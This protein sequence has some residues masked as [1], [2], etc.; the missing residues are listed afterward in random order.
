MDRVIFCLDIT[1]TS[2][3]GVL[4]DVTYDGTINVLSIQ[5]EVLSKQ[6]DYWD[7]RELLV[8]KF[9]KIKNQLEKEFD[10]KIENVIL[11][12]PS[13]STSP[14]VFSKTLEFEKGTLFTRETIRN[15]VKHI[16][17][18]KVSSTEIPACFLPVSFA[19]DGHR[20]DNP[21]GIM[22]NSL[23]YKILEISVNKKQ[24]FSLVNAIETAK[25]N[26]V[27]IVVD[28]ISE[29]FAV[30]MDMQNKKSPLILSMNDEVKAIETIHGIPKRTMWSDINF[31]NILYEVSKRYNISIEV[32]QKLIFRIVDLPERKAKVSTYFYKD[33][34]GE[35]QSID[36]ND[37][38]SFT[39]KLFEN[40]II[41][42]KNEM[43][44]FF[45]GV[46]HMVIT[47]KWAMIDGIDKMM[48]E[49]IGKT[50][51]VYRPSE[52]EIGE[53]KYARIKGACL[54]SLITEEFY[55]DK[56]NIVAFTNVT[57]K[58]VETP[59]GAG[60]VAKTA[61]KDRSIFSKFADA[62]MHDDKKE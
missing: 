28:V 19:I 56:Q 40:E 27:D 33:Q 45:A 53:P 36:A 3:T 43:N 61:K 59:S 22:G 30:S 51:H 15:E 38:V 14:G 50:V 7:D 57:E 35:Q 46:D 8:D 10:K 17:E 29:T 44:R 2:I 47:G 24:I 62:L 6:I 25:L 32:A 20:T 41:R 37:V 60:K 5:E 12:V 26:V 42:L 58:V 9:I 4:A 48:A 39:L 31:D 52:I 1:K 49:I 23:E 34:N 55:K 16:I 21:I 54:F 11:S 13:T 18:K